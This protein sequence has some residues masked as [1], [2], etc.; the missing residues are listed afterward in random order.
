MQ[1]RAARQKEGQKMCQKEVLPALKS[2]RISAMVEE[3]QEE[4]M[5]P[6]FQEKLAPQIQK[7][8]VEDEAFGLLQRQQ[9]KASQ[10]G[11]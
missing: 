6:A 5:V 11:L 1:N 2:L 9:E 10:K 8:M 7:E 3:I 4:E